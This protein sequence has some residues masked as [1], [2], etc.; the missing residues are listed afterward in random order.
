VL[1]Q[2]Q[3]LLGTAESNGDATN[4][5]TRRATRTNGVNP[6]T[7]LEVTLAANDRV[8]AQDHFQDV[9]HIRLESNQRVDYAPGDILTIYPQ[10]AKEDVDQT[11]Q[12]LGWTDVADVPLRFNVNSQFQGKI[13]AP[14]PSSFSKDG[15]MTLRSLLTKH[16][17]LNAIPRRSFFSL[18]M[19]F[20]TDE[21]QKIRLQ[22]FTDPQYTDELFDYTTRPRRSIL[23]VLQE[24]DTL[25]IPWAW[26]ATVIPPMRGRQFSISSGGKLKSNDDNNS[27]CF[28]LLVAIV[29]Y[30]TVIRKIRRGTCTRY[31]ESLPLG[32][33]LNVTLVKG[34]LGISSAD[35]HRPIVMISPGTGVAPMRS[36]IWERLQWQRNLA[37]TSEST[38]ISSTDTS[39][40]TTRD[41]NNQSTPTGQNLLIFGSRSRHADFFFANEWD[42][43]KQALPLTVLPAF[44]REQEDKVYVQDVVR[45]NAALI[46]NLVHQQD[47]IVYVCGSSGKMP[48]AVREALVDV[49]TTAYLGGRRG[50]EEYLRIMEKDGRY[51]QETW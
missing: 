12:I 27:T 38:N 22:E 9:R 45:R 11:L 51:K 35:L 28:E 4:D 13:T 19:H 47:A 36:L 49:F 44:S 40:G 30:K 17:D 29:K 20:T 25:K 33:Q 18:I 3:W 24:F 46:C 7:D 43:L 34:T 2:P 5:T 48:L 1:L 15:N 26:A 31:L 41:P 8:T 37:I 14:S 32:S 16:L 6:G 21:F 23:E 39:I 42:E 10:N 50:Q